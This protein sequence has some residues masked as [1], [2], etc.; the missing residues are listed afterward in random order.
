ME[1]I[2]RI[3]DV[4]ASVLSAHLSRVFRGRRL[5]AVLVI[6]LYHCRCRLSSSCRPSS[7]IAPIISVRV[8][9][10]FLAHYSNG[11]A[12]ATGCVVS[13]CRLRGIFQVL[14]HGVYMG[15]NQ[16]LGIPLSFPSALPFPSLPPLPLPIPPSLEV[17]PVPSLPSPPFP[18]PPFPLLYPLRITLDTYNSAS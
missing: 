15:V 12:Y 1:S 9:C 7:V 13:L 17:G 18:S 5:A 4:A 8:I 2:K 3:T 6:I 14:E 16:P 10:T 11:R